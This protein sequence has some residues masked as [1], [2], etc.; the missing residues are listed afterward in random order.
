MECRT[1]EKKIKQK[2]FS[3]IY[4]RCNKLAFLIWLVA[5][6]I[7]TNLYDTM[8]PNPIYADWNIFNILF[9]E[10]ECVYYGNGKKQKRN[11]WTDKRRISEVYEGF[12][13]EG[14]S[15]K[16]RPFRYGSNEREGKEKELTKRGR[17]SSLP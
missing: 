9:N 7:D 8:T 16:S 5:S 12:M 1:N 3:R 6:V 4:H 15:K 10:K 13:G 2:A 17:L 11:L 14:T